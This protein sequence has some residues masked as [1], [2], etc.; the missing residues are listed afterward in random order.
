MSSGTS[1]DQFCG[2]VLKSHEGKNFSFRLNFPNLILGNGLCT[3]LDGWRGGRKGSKRKTLSSKRGHFV[4]LPHTL[5]VVL[6]SLT[7]VLSWSRTGHI[8]SS[9]LG[10]GKGVQGRDVKS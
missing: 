9:N 3:E 6:P 2:K 4:S 10:S 7:S 5:S 8:Y 1:Q